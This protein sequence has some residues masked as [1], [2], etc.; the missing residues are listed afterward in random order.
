MEK[1]DVPNTDEKKRIKDESPKDEA[2]KDESP[3]DESPKD[4]A[5]KDE[6]PKDEAPKDEAPKDEAPKDE[7]PKDEAP[8]DEDNPQVSEEDVVRTLYAKEKALR[9]KI[10]NHPR[11]CKKKQTTPEENTTYTEKIQMK[12]PLTETEEKISKLLLENAEKY[13][14]LL[15]FQPV[16]ETTPL[17]IG[18]I[19]S[20]ALEDCESPEIEEVTNTTQQNEIIETKYKHLQKLP[21]TQYLEAQLHVPKQKNIFLTQCVTAHIQLLNSIKILQT[22]TPQIVHFNINPETIMYD[23]MNATPVI[24]DF[25]M[26]FTKEA[27]DNAEEFKEL[28]PVSENEYWSPEIHEISKLLETQESIEKAN[29]LKQSYATWDVYAV[30]KLVYLFLTKTLP[31]ES[32]E[33]VPFMKAY[34]DILTQT[35]NPK[36][37]TELITAIEFIFQSVSKSEYET[38]LHLCT[39]NP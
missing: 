23:K 1:T 39:L 12:S 32:L 6:A 8:K 15:Y 2:P 28:F 11:Q 33:S 21:L 14:T 17:S 26:A 16:I 37:I 13:N 3:K 38:F 25:R 9:S 29:V 31:P 24:T 34:M 30:N 36:S 27:L 10:L 20:E 5:P 4:E 19:T 18:S 7:A 22:I 35:N